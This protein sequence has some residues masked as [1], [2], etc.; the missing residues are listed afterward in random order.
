MGREPRHERL[1]R[2]AEE[3]SQSGTCARRK[4]GCVLVDERGVV[5]AT[6]Y[7][8]PASGQP[9]CID[10]PCPGVEY[11]SGEGLGECEALHAEANALIFCNDFRLINTAYVTVSP[12]VHCVKLLLNTPCKEIVF[13]EEYV[14]ESPRNLWLRAGRIWTHLGP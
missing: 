12:C 8:G 6:G 9:H 1:L 7:N 5:L 14:Q 3:V 4:V 13:R 2:L 10:C 11:D